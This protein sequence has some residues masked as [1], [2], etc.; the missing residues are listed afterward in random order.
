MV[1]RVQ[2]IGQGKRRGSS[3]HKDEDQAW[4]SAFGA[5]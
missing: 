4:T 5:Q 1:V 2:G 3:E